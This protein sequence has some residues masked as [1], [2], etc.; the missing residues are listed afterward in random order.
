MVYGLNDT[1]KTEDGLIIFFVV[2]RLVRYLCNCLSVE[3][4]CVGGS[5]SKV[6]LNVHAPKS[7]RFAKEKGRAQK[8]NVVNLRYMVQI[9]RHGVVYIPELSASHYFFVQFPRSKKPL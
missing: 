7:P 8:A 6:K 2:L 9:R 1:K 5:I 3:R 4:R